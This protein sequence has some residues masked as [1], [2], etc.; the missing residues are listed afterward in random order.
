MTKSSATILDGDSPPHGRGAGT[1]P[2]NT[3]APDSVL[4][5]QTGKLLQRVARHREER[6]REL[7]E[8]AAAEV[9]GI[10]R[11]ARA[12]ARAAVHAAVLQERARLAEGARQAEAN[13][14]LEVRRRAQEETR[15]LL[16][17]LWTGIE[18]VLAARWRNEESRRAWIEAA[19]T[20]AGLLLGGRAW[21]IERSPRWPESESRTAEAL[22]RQRGAS[23]VDW[24]SD[25]RLSA[26]LRVRA[27][28]ASLDASIAGLLARRE[29]VE[30]AFL[31]E[32]LHE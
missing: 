7:R 30:S 10:V 22:A 3:R 8:A 6:C 11:S 9:R 15:E 5:L 24:V 32:Y 16:G 25:E 21:T 4:D 23:A 19:L 29:E 12:E 18:S 28:S 14:A 17:E 26:G 31:A 27:G 1:G 20:E 13:A 2:R